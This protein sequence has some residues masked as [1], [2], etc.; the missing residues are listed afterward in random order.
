MTESLT[1]RVNKATQQ[2]ESASEVFSQV[3]CADSSTM[4]ETGCGQVPSL[5]K[6]LRDLGGYQ[7]QGAWVS[8][9][10]YEEKD[11]IKDI[12][13]VI[14]LCIENHTA[15]SDFEEDVQAGKW[16]VFQAINDSPVFY[17]RVV[18]FGLGV[19]FGPY[20]EDGRTLLPRLRIGAVEYV[21]V[22]EI[23]D[24]LTFTSAEIDD[25]F[26]GTVGVQTSIGEQV[27]SKIAAE[28][29]TVKDIELMDLTGA[30][31]SYKTVDEAK[32]ETNTDKAVLYI[33]GRSNACYYRISATRFNDD[34]L[35]FEDAGGNCWG[36]TRTNG[37]LN[38]EHLGLSQNGVDCSEIINNALSLG[39]T[40]KLPIG[41][42]Y[43]SNLYINGDKQI[44]MGSG[45]STTLIR[46]DDS[47][48]PVITIGHTRRAYQNE[49]RDL[50][51]DGRW[52]SSDNPDPEANSDGIRFMQTLG[53]KV[54][55][56]HVKSMTGRGIL[57]AAY[58]D[59][60]TPYDDLVLDSYITNS[61]IENCYRGAV[62]F[63]SYSA[64]LE[65]SRCILS[66]GDGTENHPSVNIGNVDSRI[67]GNHVIGNV[68]VGSRYCQFY[69]NHVESAQQH[70]LI[71][72]GYNA[73]I[74]DNVFI[75]HSRQT[76]NTYSGIYV[77][78]AKYV[79]IT[80]NV[81]RHIQKYG[82]TISSNAQGVV[83]KN[84]ILE[85]NETG[86]L[87]IED[88]AKEVS[89]ADNYPDLN[90]GTS[91]SSRQTFVDFRLGDNDLEVTLPIK[92]IPDPNNIAKGYTGKL[93]IDFTIGLGP[94]PPT[95]TGYILFSRG[96]RSEYTASIQISS[97]SSDSALLYTELRTIK[98][99]TNTGDAEFELVW[100]GSGIAVVVEHIQT[101]TPLNKLEVGSMT[102]VYPSIT[103][104]E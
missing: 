77:D 61:R 38:G 76:A 18:E 63:S 31:K 1:S 78:T 75:K 81:C 74:N 23:V 103:R 10:L 83:C 8:G 2:I 4:V 102:F 44:L 52:K 3:K 98:N 84:N 26:D 12:N 45:L 33:T 64:T 29:V 94:T 69:G 15:S 54:S 35:D 93:A 79:T 80:G 24:S 57:L 37:I 22:S 97:Q 86:G 6:V 17:R 68:K 100:K 71:V 90:D 65:L 43:V 49:I 32:A 87:K 59:P 99:D 39:G 9:F 89:V 95:A 28:A 91:S 7:Y 41:N 51:I 40:L 72:T 48:G 20:E 66:G 13:G 82:I 25:R 34:V 55:N 36:L 56:V 21:A 92:C 27:F 70:G 104:T 50:S 14:W 96:Y 16:T 58:Q 53:C 60:E 46:I 67:F 101:R 5:R 19:A 85:G 73:L 42:Y 88:G 62:D 47:V 11:Q 30:S